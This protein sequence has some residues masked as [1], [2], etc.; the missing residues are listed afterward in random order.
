[1][2]TGLRR[3]ALLKRRIEVAKQIEALDPND[4][5]AA[6]RTQMLPLLA[7]EDALDK[8]E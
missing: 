7:E 4:Q 8:D 6:W 5:V 1:M 2:E 3:T